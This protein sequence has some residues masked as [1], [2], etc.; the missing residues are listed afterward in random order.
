MTLPETEKSLEK[1]IKTSIAD[2]R[3][4][5]ELNSQNWKKNVEKDKVRIAWFW[6]VVFT[7]FKKLG[8][9]ILNQNVL[10]LAAITSVAIVLFFNHNNTVY[11]W[12]TNRNTNRQS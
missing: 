4:M 9:S 10:T 8:N 2:R 3:S 6:F 1:D 12:Y 11:D 5:I 7:Q